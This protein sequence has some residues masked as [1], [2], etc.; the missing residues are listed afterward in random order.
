MIGSISD[1]I[2]LLAQNAM[3]DAI[4]FSSRYS[5]T[6]QLSLKVEISRNEFIAHTKDNTLLPYGLSD[7]LQPGVTWQWSL[8]ADQEI[9]R[10]VLLNVKYEGRSEPQSFSSDRHITHTGRAEIRASF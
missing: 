1:P 5:A 7:G 3:T 10:G 8:G 6:N 9:T 4:L 2:Y